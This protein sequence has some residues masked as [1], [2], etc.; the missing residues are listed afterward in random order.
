MMIKNICS[1][2]RN[3]DGCKLSE[4]ILAMDMDCLVKE[5]ETEVK[6]YL[7]E[8]D[9]PNDDNNR[10]LMVY[11]GS[12]PKITHEIVSDHSNHGICL[13]L[14]K[15]FNKIKNKF[16][17]LEEMQVP[18]FID[19]GSFERFN[20]FLKG[21]MEASEYFN[22]NEC[23][24]YFQKITDE[25]LKLFKASKNPEN[26]I[27]TIPEVI[28]NS[29][30]TQKLQ[31]EFLEQY[32]EMQLYYYCKIIVSMQFDPNSDNLKEEIRNSANWIS[33]NINV[34]FKIGVPFGNDFKKIQN[35]DCMDYIDELF[36]GLLF[37]YTAHLF[38]C[39]TIN[40]VKKFVIPY[41]WIDSIDASSINVWSTHKIIDIRNITGKRGKQ[42]LNDKKKAIMKSEGID[43]NNWS[44]EMKFGERFK[45]N[46]KNFI[47][48][49][50]EILNYQNKPIF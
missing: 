5:I 15:G 30:L 46:L 36:N 19:N 16:D 23:R 24:T 22:Y 33:Q 7:E 44:N 49:L 27:I 26:I 13:N 45:I 20:K 9:Y 38:A 18:I 34:D 40:K 29:E 11:H 3:K 10:D 39:G 32:V 28:G 2:C 1:N 42:S 4:M 6:E 47:S 50:T 41:Y 48:I 14:D 43:A 12:S 25:Y 21:K 8:M 37:G 35:S 31:S 17:Y